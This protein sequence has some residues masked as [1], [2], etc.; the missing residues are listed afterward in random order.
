M[1]DS[2]SYNEEDVG[3]AR[4]LFFGFLLITANSEY[5]RP[6]GQMA[7]LLYCEKTMGVWFNL[8]LSSTQIELIILTYKIGLVGS[9]LGLL[10][11]LSFAISLI[12]LSVLNIYVLKFCYFSHHLMPIHISLF[13]WLLLDRNSAYRLDNFLFKK[14]MRSPGSGDPNFLFGVMKWHFVIIFFLSGLAKLRVAGIDWIITDSLEKTVLM[15]NFYY[16]NAPARAHFA[17]LNT[18][19]M[20]FPLVFNFMAFMTIFLELIAPVALLSKKAARWIVSDLL[21]MQVGI[22]LVMFIKFSP[23][24]ALY[25]FWIPFSRKRR[26][27]IN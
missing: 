27:R 17:S 4:I 3:L 15:Q 2:Y 21:I 14:W 11:R 12:S 13:F 23:W 25:V 9:L 8:S 16:E 24:I 19:L 7:P 20:Q 6:F 1:K 5:W 22:Y 10:T 18:F 26:W